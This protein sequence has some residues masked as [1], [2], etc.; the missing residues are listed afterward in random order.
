MRRRLISFVILALTGC[1][2]ISVTESSLTN[3]AGVVVINY[4]VEST[5]QMNIID[6][7][8]TGEQNKV[9]FTE[10]IAT[11]VQDIDHSLE[12]NIVS[13]PRLHLERQPVCS[14]DIL[15]SRSESE[16]YLNV[17]LSGYGSIKPLWKD[18][19][20]ASGAVE[21]VVQGVVIGAATQNPWFGLA[22]SAEEMTSEYLTWNGVDWLLGETYA[23]VTLEGKLTYVKDHKV[24]WANS[25]FVTEND[26]ELAKL[27]ASAKKDKSKQLQ[28]SLHKAEHKLFS[29]L[30]A[31][32]R[33]AAL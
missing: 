11:A 29:N 21:A 2:S 12:S 19:L 26:E 18:F 3:G 8:L 15:S 10:G 23:P 22:A 1:A 13:S 6:K 9:R 16:L 17:D 31:Y 20:I 24:I 33:Q 5:A 27:G 25:Y 4:C 32:L 30:N 14:I 28:A 7:H